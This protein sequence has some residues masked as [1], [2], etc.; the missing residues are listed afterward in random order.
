M[1][2]LQLQLRILHQVLLT[3]PERELPVTVGS[4]Y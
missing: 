1:S 2:Y 4:R 3:S